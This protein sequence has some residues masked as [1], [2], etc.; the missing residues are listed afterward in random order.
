M[1]NDPGRDL[2][3]WLDA[4]AEGSAEEADR[5]FAAM[6][7]RHVSRLQPAPG[8]ADRVIAVC[9]TI[10][11]RARPDAS[12]RPG[13]VLVP[14]WS[15]AAVFVAL[16][17]GGLAAALCSSASVFDLVRAIWVGGPGAFRTVAAVSSI[18]LGA[19]GHAWSVTISIGRALAL[20]ATSAPGTAVIVANLTLA[21]VASI[22]LKHLL[23]P[24]EELS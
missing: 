3:D 6:F 10:P 14:R 17:L 13:A 22:G 18:G 4:E 1:T 2:E 19:W 24:D 7:S 20:V 23:P 9:R 16:V 8:L 15:R 21:L 11:A 12:Q 5:S